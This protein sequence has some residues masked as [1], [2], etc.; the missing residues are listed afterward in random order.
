MRKYADQISLAVL[1]GEA[2]SGEEDGEQ[3][4]AWLERFTRNEHLF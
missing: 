4:R 3:A 2:S 1:K